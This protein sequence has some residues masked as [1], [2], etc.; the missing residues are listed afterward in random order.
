MLS[1]SPS[2]YPGIGWLSTL[3]RKKAA[4]SALLTVRLKISTRDLFFYEK[5]QRW[6]GLIAASTEQSSPILQI[7]LS[8]H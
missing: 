1:R 3:K 7:T 5:Q 8:Y 4:F 6:Q 2:H